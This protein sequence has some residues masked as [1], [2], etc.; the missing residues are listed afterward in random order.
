MDEAERKTTEQNLIEADDA[1][2][3]GREDIAKQMQLIAELTRE[4]YDIQAATELLNTLH[5][6]Q[7]LLVEQRDQL[8]RELGLET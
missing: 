3:Q 8:R 6:S 2:V 5:Q 1:I 4:G 7:T